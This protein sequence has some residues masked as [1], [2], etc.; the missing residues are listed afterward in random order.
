MP[1]G[2]KGHGVSQE[3]RPGAGFKTGDSVQEKLGGY[4][5]TMP[6]SYPTKV[7]TP[8]THLTYEDRS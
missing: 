6:N 2:G 7:G 1:R 4:R 8:Q 5:R 3:T